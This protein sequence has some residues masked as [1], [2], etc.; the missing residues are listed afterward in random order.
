MRPVPQVD[1]TVEV[2]AND[3]VLAKLQSASWEL[4]V[5]LSPEDVERLRDIR[6]ANWDERRSIPAG[7]SAGAA[8][9]WASEAD[10]VSILIGHDDETWDVAVTVPVETVDRLV[11]EATNL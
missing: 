10:A 2:T 4:N 1:V 6:R 7:S 8:V 3:F 9:F 5:L 11:V